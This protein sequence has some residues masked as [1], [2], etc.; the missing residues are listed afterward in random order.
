MVVVLLAS[1]VLFGAYIPDDF[2]CEGFF[3]HAP[4]QIQT[5]PEAARIEIGEITLMIDRISAGWVRIRATD[6]SNGQLSY[7]YTICSSSGFACCGEITF[8][9]QQCADEPHVEIGTL[10]ATLPVPHAAL[11]G[12]HSSI[13][14]ELVPH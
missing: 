7:S 12:F 1:P 14:L 10:W 6:L 5:D 13:I 9:Y 8:P 4:E 3:L 11:E 2:R